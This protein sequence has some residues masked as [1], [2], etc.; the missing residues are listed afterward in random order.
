[1]STDPAVGWGGPGGFVYQ[2]AYLEFFCS[3][4]LLKKLMKIAVNYPSLTYTAV[5]VNGEVETSLSPDERTA[6]NAVTWGVF[7][8]REVIQP[9]IV[10]ISSFMAWKDEAFALWTSQW[11]HLYPENST[12]Y[13]LI[14]QIRDTYYLVNVV[15]NDFIH[16]DLFQIFDSILADS[17]GRSR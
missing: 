15:D 6:V 4:D 7:P 9:T 17:N 5:N 3:I 2:K 8:N 13:K 16:G 12:G 11:R 14:S 1:M 10:E